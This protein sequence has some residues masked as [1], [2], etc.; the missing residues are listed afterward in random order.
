MVSPLRRQQSSSRKK[1]KR[2]LLPESESR[3]IF[4]ETLSPRHIISQR[5]LL[6]PE[7]LCRTIK[8]I[9]SQDFQDN[10]SVI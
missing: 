7:N 3:K 9:V 6:S 1:A 5:F 4:K 8:G 10:A 2:K